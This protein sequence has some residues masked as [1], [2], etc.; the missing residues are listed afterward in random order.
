M[1]PNDDAE[2]RALAQDWTQPVRGDDA[3]F[4]TLQQV[5]ARAR[6]QQYVFAGELLLCAGVLAILL[7]RAAAGADIA[8]V[9]A[10]AAFTLFALAASIWAWRARDAAVAESV[11]NALESAIA[12]CAVWLRWIVAGYAICAAALLY[13]AFLFLYPPGVQTLVLA[14]GTLFVA[15]SLFMLFFLQRRQ[16]R[17]RD[18]LLALRTA[19]RD[20]AEAP[21]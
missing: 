16:Q 5:R 19:L 15:L 8:A 11:Q 9:A 1:N 4:P 2:W 13:L 10:G 20:D 7:W 14:L 12:Q 21:A 17:Y 18:G 3:L 6:L